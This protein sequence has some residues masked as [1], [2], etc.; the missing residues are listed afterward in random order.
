MSL[1]LRQTKALFLDAYREL[2]ARKLFWVTLALSVLVVSAFTAISIKDGSIR[3]LWWT[4]DANVRGPMADPAKFYKAM[5][6][7]FGIDIWLAWA[8]MVLALISSASIF[9]DFLSGG[10]IELVLSKPMSRLRLFLT[11]YATGLLFVAIQVGVFATACFMLIGVKGGSWDFRV[12]LAV[13]IIV[14]VYSFLFCVCALLGIVTR[15]TI[16][17]LLLTLLVWF[18]IFVVN[19]ADRTIAQ[20]ATMN[21]VSRE[22]LPLRIAQWEK[23]AANMY[24]VKIK[25]ERLKAIEAAQERQESV[26][27]LT[28]VDAPI[29]EPTRAQL[30]ETYAKLPKGRADLE[31][32]QRS[33]EDWSLARRIA[34]GVKFVLPKTNESPE[35]LKR[36][37]LEPEDL[38]HE[39]DRDPMRDVLMGLVAGDMREVQRRMELEA[40][41]K[42]LWWVL[43][44]SFA[45][46][47]VILC[48]AG[49]VFARK[50]F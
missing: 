45:F 16:A 17:S 13:P 25:A 42:P 35:L 29:P 41:A 10:A 14:G 12:F 26:D 11:K 9:P 5:F 39:D 20:F 50:E 15:S 33:A 37:L 36:F 22:R 38:I 27:A 28:P 3:F 48:I 6:V 34:Q 1:V 4:V 31:S 8:A 46:E 47:G 7:T 44:T 21:E 19:A 43:G 49:W 18:L 23:T 24:E 30:D 32:Q 40:R 2:N